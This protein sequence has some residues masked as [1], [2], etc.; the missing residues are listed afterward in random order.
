MSYNL[1]ISCIKKYKK[2]KKWKLKKKRF[3]L[4][5]NIKLCQRFFEF[6]VELMWK[7]LQFWFI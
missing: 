6:F 1:I 2:Y 4:L 7:F 3:L 5:I